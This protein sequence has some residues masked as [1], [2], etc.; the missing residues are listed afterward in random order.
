M[1]RDVFN[2]VFDTYR[3]RS[4]EALEESVGQ[5]VS[6]SESTWFICLR[7]HIEEWKHHYGQQDQAI[8]QIRVKYQFLQQSLRELTETDQLALRTQ[9][10]KECQAMESSF[11]LRREMIFER[12][13]QELMINKLSQ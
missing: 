1:T 6:V 12:H 3:Q 8:Q 5:Q 2:K 13:Q 4:I 7:G 10:E 11:G 9:E